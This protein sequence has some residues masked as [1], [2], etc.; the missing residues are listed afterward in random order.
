MDENVHPTVRR[1]RPWSCSPERQRRPETEKGGL[2]SSWES[3]RWS[4]HPESG[5]GESE[6]TVTPPSKVL[7]IA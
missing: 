5:R 3:F 2:C 1:D 6:G 4:I 7:I